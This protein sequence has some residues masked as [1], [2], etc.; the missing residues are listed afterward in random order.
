MYFFLNTGTWV[1]FTPL[2]GFCPPLFH[3][4]QEWCYSKHCTQ[5]SA[6]DKRKLHLISQRTNRSIQCHSVA[7]L[8]Y[9]MNVLK[10]KYPINDPLRL[11]QPINHIFHN[12]VQ[13]EMFFSLSFPGINTHIHTHKQG[14]HNGVLSYS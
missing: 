6:L 2:S 1:G 7:T 11:K 3:F 12:P 5:Q 4:M 10:F 14:R 8:Q 9:G 13:Q